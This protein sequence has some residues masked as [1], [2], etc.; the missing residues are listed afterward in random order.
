M[1]GQAGGTG[2]ECHVRNEA[3][4]YVRIWHLMKMEFSNEDV[5][6]GH[7]NNGSKLERNI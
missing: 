1:R 6:S 2:A 4:T 3:R 5:K 7:P